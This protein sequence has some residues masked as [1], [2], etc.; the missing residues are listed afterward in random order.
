MHAHKEIE[1]LSESKGDCRRTKH[2]QR[3]SLTKNLEHDKAFEEVICDET[4]KRKEEIED[5]KREILQGGWDSVERRCP[6]KA[7]VRC[8]IPYA[9]QKD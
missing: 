6:S 2:D 3:S 7:S 9:N 8:N 4:D 5:V 1:D